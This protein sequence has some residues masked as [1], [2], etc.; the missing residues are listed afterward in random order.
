MTSNVVIVDRRRYRWHREC[1]MS[2]IFV[3]TPATVEETPKCNL[4]TEI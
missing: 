3:P 1:E 4:E 2:L